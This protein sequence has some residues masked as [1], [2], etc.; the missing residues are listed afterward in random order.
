LKIVCILGHPERSEGSTELII[1]ILRF[2]QNDNKSGKRLYNQRR[3][4]DILHFA[5][6][7]LHSI[8]QTP[9]YRTNIKILSHF[10]FKITVDFSTLKL[11][12]I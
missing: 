4:P 8:L 5:F 3:R 6:C 1:E 10:P 2:A 12:N 9:I 11:Y 7:V